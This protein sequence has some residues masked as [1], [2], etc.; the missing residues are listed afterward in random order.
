MC[1]SFSSSSSTLVKLVLE[2]QFRIFIYI[3]VKNI[4]KN[5]PSTIITKLISRY[6]YLRIP[7]KD[8]SFIF[9]G[10]KIATIKI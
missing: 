7:I 6:T 8:I 1:L 9:K 2:P 10:R 4:V 5:I 3:I